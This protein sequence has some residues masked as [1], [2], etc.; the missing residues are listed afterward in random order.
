MS[1]VI[2]E[3]ELGLIRQRLEAIEEALA[4]EMSVDDKAALQEALQEHRAGRSVAF[5]PTRSRARKR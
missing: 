3:K 2:L 4:E 5:K 1:K